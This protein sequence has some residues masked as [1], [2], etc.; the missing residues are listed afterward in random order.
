MTGST[1]GVGG[2]TACGGV[3][4]RGKMSASGSP[5]AAAQIHRAD[6]MTCAARSAVAHKSSYE[7]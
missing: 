6:D 5:C 1:E 7:N 4:A 2:G 3:N